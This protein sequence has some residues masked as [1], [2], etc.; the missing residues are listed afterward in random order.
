MSERMDTAVE[1]WGTVPDWVASLVEACDHS[2]QNKVAGR[3]GRSAAVVS[4]VLRNA[5]AGNMRAVEQR[6]RDVL[7]A[8]EIAC[9]ALGP[10]SSEDCLNWRDRAEKH[11]SHSPIQV[12][13]FSACRRCHRFNPEEDAT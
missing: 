5:Y 9:P 1:N 2:S 4:Q 3:I 6:V 11:S 10:I 8:E 13:M 12:R 7:M